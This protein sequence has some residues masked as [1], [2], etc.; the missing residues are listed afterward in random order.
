[1]LPFDYTELFLIR[2]G[3]TEESCQNLGANISG[4]QYDVATKKWGNSWQM[5]SSEQ[6]KE[7][8]DNCTCEWVEYGGTKGVKFTGLN[9][10]FIFLPAA[11]YHDGSELFSHGSYGYYWSG[12]PYSSYKYCAYGVFFNSNIVIPLPGPIRSPCR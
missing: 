9:D 8:V 10:G 2:S 3:G 7:L 6:I 4:T 12:T 5:P 11:G 1:V